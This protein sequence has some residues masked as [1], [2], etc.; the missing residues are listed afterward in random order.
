MQI[1]GEWRVEIVQGDKDKPSD[2]D[3]C[4]YLDNC[5]HACPAKHSDQ[6]GPHT[7]TSITSK[8]PLSCSTQVYS[9]T[10]EGSIDKEGCT[11]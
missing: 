7:A 9:A 1:D 11:R 6:A 3:D 10:T 5:L 8:P 4:Q 2:R